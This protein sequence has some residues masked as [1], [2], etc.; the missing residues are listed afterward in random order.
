MTKLS[1]GPSRTDPHTR[2]ILSEL[3]FW[4]IYDRFMRDICSQN[5]IT[6]PLGRGYMTTFPSVFSIPNG[7]RG[8]TDIKQ[9]P[10]SEEKVD[11]FGE[12][13]ERKRNII[14]YLA[15][16]T[17]CTHC[18]SQAFFC[19]NRLTPTVGLCRALVK[20]IPRP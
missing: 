3:V 11:I 18:A 5:R 19:K 4:P 2:S 15:K 16:R 6:F 12:K 1:M 17:S 7:G 8:R 9:A 13:K 14:E 10:Y 20:L